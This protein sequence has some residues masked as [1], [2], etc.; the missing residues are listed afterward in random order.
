MKT[1]IDHLV[2][3][4]TDLD[5]GCA[6]VTDA[7]GVALQP[8]GVHSR[9]GT[10]NRL[11]HLGPGLY[12]EVIAVDPSA[13][14][15]DRARWFGLDQLAPHSPARLATWVARTDDIHAARD[16]C[17][18]LV[19]DVEPMTRGTLNWQITVPADGSLPM[20]GSIPTLIQWAPGPHP[21]DM[22]Q[23]KGCTLLALD[24]FHTNPEKIKAILTAMN[25]SGPVH[26]HAL[27]APS[28]PYL[29]AHIQTPN[30]L[31]TLPLLHV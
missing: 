4:A 27:Q 19:G 13:I 3:V 30:G 26:L 7:L 29:V 31:K 5:T 1:T 8:G 18:G 21:A 20:D 15:P 10:H 22:L 2:I 6:F 11:L 14:R 16:A 24:V 23:D 9:M 17:P 12:L 25:F 28:A